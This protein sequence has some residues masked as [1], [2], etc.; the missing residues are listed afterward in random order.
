M[1]TAPSRPIPSHSAQPLTKPWVARVI[2]GIHLVA[3]LMMGAGFAA[4]QTVNNE[5]DLLLQSPLR[6]DK[7]LAQDP[8]R[9]PLELLSFAKVK[10]GWRGFVDCFEEVT[11]KSFQVKAIYVSRRPPPEAYTTWVDVAIIFD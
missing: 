1:S 10:P 5:W 8:T 11:D 7:D 3:S 6:L 2:A 9:K 4:A